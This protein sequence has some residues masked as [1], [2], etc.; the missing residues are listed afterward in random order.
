VTGPYTPLARRGGLRHLVDGTGPPAAALV[1]ARTGDTGAFLDL[2]RPHD[3]ELRALALGPLGDA[4]VVDAAL[5]EVYLQAFRALDAYRGDAAFGDWLREVC[6]LVVRDIAAHRPYDRTT[7]SGDTAVIDVRDDP[8]PPSPG[9]WESVARDLAAGSAT[10]P[11]PAWGGGVVPQPSGSTGRRPFDGFAVGPAV[12]PERVAP[13]EWAPEPAPASPVTRLSSWMWLG[14]AGGVVLV[15]G[16]IA[17]TS[18]IRGFPGLPFAEDDDAAASPVGADASPTPTPEASG[19]QSAVEGAAG[20]VLQ[21]IPAAQIPAEVLADGGLEGVPL[22]QAFRW[23]DENGDNVLVLTAADSTLR[24]YLFAG[25]PEGL[26]LMR[27]MSDPGAEGC[28]AGQV[29]QF[30]DGSVRLADSDGDGLAEVTVA[31]SFACVGHSGPRTVKLALLEGAD[32]YILRGEGH[33]SPQ[34]ATS[35]GSGWPGASF[36]EDPGRL[37][38]PPGAFESTTELFR[39]FFH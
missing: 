14:L 28:P 15:V 11:G 36:V 39:E 5:R 13:V 18:L 31:W 26:Q 3:A 4:G 7:A 32:K 24:T 1:R 17:I 2:V 21:P 10:R 8:P 34:E 12:A 37:Q 19:G 22:P 33:L 27:S 30:T 25:P 38:W 29:N 35:A 23:V 16:V 20:P 9:F 6:R